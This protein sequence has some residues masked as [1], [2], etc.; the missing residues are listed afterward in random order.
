MKLTGG[1]PVQAIADAANSADA[2]LVLAS[3]PDPRSVADADCG[4]GTSL[5]K[6]AARGEIELSVLAPEK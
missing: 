3:S 5:A 6:S 4:A 1:E 2:L